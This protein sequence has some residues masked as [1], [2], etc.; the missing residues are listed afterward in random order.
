[1]KNIEDE[2]KEKAEARDKA[3]DNKIYKFLEKIRR[4]EKRTMELEVQGTDAEKKERSLKKGTQIF[5]Q[6]LLTLKTQT[7]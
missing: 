4:E 1:M 3:I 6:L 5:N 2:T 7:P